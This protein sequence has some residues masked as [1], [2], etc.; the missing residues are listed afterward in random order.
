MLKINCLELLEGRNNYKQEKKTT[1]FYKINHFSMQFS[2]VLNIFIVKKKLNF[3]FT[4]D[5]KG[6]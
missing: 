2:A 5:L 1:C 4:N 3:I 6:K